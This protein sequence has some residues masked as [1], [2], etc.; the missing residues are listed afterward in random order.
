MLVSSSPAV[1]IVAMQLL[2]AQFA[3]FIEHDSLPGLRSYERVAAR[4]SP[5]HGRGLFAMDDLPPRCVIALY[6]VDAIGRDDEASGR[7]LRAA[8]ADDVAEFNKLERPAAYRLYLERETG[9]C[10]DANP[11]RPQCDGWLAHL[12]NDGCM[13]RTDAPDEVSDY[14]QASLS[15][16]NCCFIPFGTAPLLAAVTTQPVRKGDELLTSYGVS[17]WVGDMPNGMP[18]LEWRGEA[19]RI[20]GEQKLVARDAEQE[21]AAAADALSE[22]LA[23][24]LEIVRESVESMEAVEDCYRW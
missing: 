15:R 2:R 24:A 6:P 7:F 8:S 14:L 20:L 22:G 10:V 11:T 9:L 12:I 4:V 3:S 5:T 13:C 21:H 16:Q 19:E 17:Y 1:I 18:N 23:M